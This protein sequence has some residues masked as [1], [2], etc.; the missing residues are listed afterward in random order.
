MKLWDA[1]IEDYGLEILG[2]SPRRT[3]E[4]FWYYCQDGQKAVY[5]A[6]HKLNVDSETQESESK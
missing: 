1:F 2:W 6:V 4:L 5:N 3:L